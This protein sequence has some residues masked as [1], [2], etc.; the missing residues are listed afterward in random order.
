MKINELLDLTSNYSKHEKKIILSFLLNCSKTEL[1]IKEE[2]T[3]KKII[4][5]YKK[6]I[7]KDIPVQYL[8][9]SSYF[10]NNKFF[11]NKNV[12]IPRP[13]TEILVDETNNLINK[14]FTNK[15]ISICD[16]G[17]GSGVIAI[18]MNILN[19]NAIVDAVDISNKA[20]KVAKINNKKL[21]TKVNFIHGNMLNNLKKKYD[22][23]ISN[24]PYLEETA[25]H[26][27]EKVLKYEPHLALFGGLK[28]YE[29]IL[30]NASKYLNKKS[31]IAFE[32]G[33][34]Q[35]KDINKIVNKYFKNSKI[36]N[37]KDL[38]GYDRYIFILNN[39]E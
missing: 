7:K 35:K 10:F 13:E 25:S 2:I 20:L 12:L 23:I 37:K 26:I 19:K 36:V 28:Y 34:N 17:T 39:I 21:N 3:D 38:N 24:P 31:I 22:V 16:I 18:T 1:I 32:I 14:Y 8:L 29:E 9:K 11:V 5:K 4:N 33:Y 15:E 27:E 30:S 6:L